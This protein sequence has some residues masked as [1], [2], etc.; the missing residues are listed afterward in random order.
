ML[1]N[2][3]KACSAGCDDEHKASCTNLKSHLE[4]ICG[5][6]MDTCTAFCDTATEGGALKKTACEVKAA[7]P[8]ADAKADP[9]KK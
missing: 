7:G 3:L 6:S 4:K 8:K 5:V 1:E 2:A 9:A